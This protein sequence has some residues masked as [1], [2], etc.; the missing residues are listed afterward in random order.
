M[1]AKVL[2][3]IDLRD[4]HGGTVG[5][6]QYLLSYFFEN[7]TLI[8]KVV[9]RNG[10]G[11]EQWTL[12]KVNGKKLQDVP[13]FIL[14]NKETAS[15]AE[16][17]SYV[18]KNEKRGVVVGETTMGAAHSVGSWDINGFSISIPNQRGIS[19]ITNTNWESV[20]VIPDVTS[21]DDESFNL[22]FNMAKEVANNYK[23]SYDSTITKKYDSLWEL[24]EKTNKQ[25]LNET[26]GNKIHEIVT[27][28]VERNIM[29]ELQI[30]DLG[31]H[32]IELKMPKAAE[33]V[34]KSN[35]LVYF[36]SANAYDS[37]AETLAING[38]LKES[39]QNYKKAIK[40]ASEQ[41]TGTEELHRK[42]L[43]KIIELLKSKKD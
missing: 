31:Y 9:D 17:F 40:L 11:T 14:V 21:S 2:K 33:M 38:K 6:V 41:N 20:G 16:G 7:P 13:L 27:Y 3:I 22:A 26:E 24:L 8:A 15:G 4:N 12:K 28:L 42:S 19:P 1:R 23:T 32:Y 43:D 25:E 30:N 29:N 18:I 39:I 5:M 35:T 37:Y 10:Q 36:N 34:F